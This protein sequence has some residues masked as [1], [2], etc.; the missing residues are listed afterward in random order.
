MLVQISAGQG[1][2]EC[3]LAVGKLFEVWKKE[4]P[5]IDLISRREGRSKGCFHSVLFETG[6]DMSHLEGTIL[7]ICKSPV[8]PG[9]KRK[10]WYVDVSIIPE[11]DEIPSDADYRFEKFHS[12]GKGGQNVNKV[13]TGVRVIHIPTGIT[14]TSTEERSQYMNKQ[15][16][17]KR[18]QGILAAIEQDAGN[19]Q[20]NQA[21]REHTRI[22][23]GNPVRV[24]E[25][26]DFKMKAS[27]RIF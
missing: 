14:V 17:L 21:W 5:D 12:G 19:K 27:Y 4:F 11:R 13:E 15:K 20:A 1:P 6:T 2:E 9:H 25:G 3:Q 16:A 26:M 10:N 18:L 22:V 24:Y 7:W 23:R 8:R